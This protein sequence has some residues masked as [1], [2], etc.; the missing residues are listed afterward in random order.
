MIKTLPLKLNERISEGGLSLSGGERQRI[1][2]VRALLREPEVLI[3]DEA[4]SALDYKLEEKIMLNIENIRNDRT[5]IIISHRI[6]P[7]TNSDIIY[8]FENGKIIA[9]GKHEY[10]RSESKEYRRM[11]ELDS[12]VEV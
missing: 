5:T 4:T 9:Q 6:A 10:L 7:I 3:L 11:L 2:L 1:A 8:I 12:Y